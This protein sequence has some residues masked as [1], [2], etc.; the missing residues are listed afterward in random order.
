[1]HLKNK[2]LIEN[3]AK[4]ADLCHKHS[5]NG[6]T[7]VMTNGCFDVLHSGHTYIL[8][9]AK[10]LGITTYKLVQ[11]WPIDKK[12]FL[13]WA[14]GLELIVV[15]EE[16]RKLIEGQVKE[17]LFDELKGR[18]VFGATK[19]DAAKSLFHSKGALDASYIAEQLGK[20]WQSR[21]DERR[22]IKLVPANE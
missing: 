11:T 15:V 1:M 19:G 18:R 17:A 9:E 3:L 5:H 22:K 8:E 10:K 12:S 16:K 21:I 13:E 20:I 2:K 7:I 14:E 6:K 4:L